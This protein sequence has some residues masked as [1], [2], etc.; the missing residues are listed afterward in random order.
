MTK[1]PQTYHHGNNLK[2]WYRRGL[3]SLRHITV[4]INVFFVKTGIHFNFI[5][6]TTC[7]GKS[8]LIVKLKHENSFSVSSKIFYLGT[9]KLC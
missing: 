2:C 9:K 8:W 7:F 3:K 6:F 1:I 5:F 4:F